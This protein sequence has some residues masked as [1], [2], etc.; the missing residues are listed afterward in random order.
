M[1]RYLLVNSN[2]A[3]DSFSQL[4]ASNWPD[5]I[6]LVASTSYGIAAC[7]RAKLP[8]TT[9]DR[10]S[11]RSEII[12]LGWHNYA[13]LTLFCEHWDSAAQDCTPC[14]KDRS[15]KPFRFGYFDLK[16]LIDSISTKLLMLKN[17]IHYASGQ[18]IF[19][20]PELGHKIISGDFL[21]PDSNVNMFAVLLETFFNDKAKLSPL[22]N[23]STEAPS[24]LSSWRALAR[25]KLRALR[26]VVRAS[27]AFRKNRTYGKYLCF[28]FGHDISYIVPHLLNQQLQLIY[29]PTTSTS[30]NPDII[31]EC[32][33]LWQM[34]LTSEEFKE[35]FSHDEISYFSLVKDSLEKYANSVLPRAIA[36]HDHL[37]KILPKLDI[38]FSLT[39]TV[40]LGLVNRCRMLAAQK[41]G[42]PL[43]TY[44]EGAGY[45]SIVSPIYDFTE[46]V[47]GDAMLCY[48]AGNVEYYKDSGASTKP[49]IP[50]GSAHQDAIRI[51]LRP[52]PPPDQ[53]R[54]VMYAGTVADDNIMHCP[55]NGLV[56]T[57]YHSSQ[58]SI[59]QLLASMPASTKVIA[60]P[61]P[62]DA[63][64]PA[65]LQSAEFRR[66]HLETRRFEKAM[67]GVDL[68]IL[69]FPSTVLLSCI[70]TTAYVFVLAEEGVTGFTPKQKERLEK[71]AYLFENLESLASAVR[72]I[73]VS[74][75]QFPL[76]LD[77]SY[78]MAYSLYMP[79]GKSAERAAK[80]L[81]EF[82]KGRKL[83][84]IHA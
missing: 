62:H 72:N 10:Y 48:G 57:L 25:E 26:G 14:L 27:Q 52:M 30:A 46:V 65:V 11:T 3:L 54:T 69:D 32:H 60:K 53:I 20:L 33:F 16:I 35:F 34:L 51:C 77:D 59:F 67:H 56:S 44:Q 19:Y 28:N 83:Q 36:E 2:Q 7:I 49:L 31:K 75:A 61:N 43:I 78:L 24:I 18:E 76:R 55:N 12:N 6:I 82:S 64:T 45:G 81:S 42:A 40:N 66:I 74:T 29:P 9:L 38:K 8:Y 70:A 23:P 50:V 4:F 39:G 71:R 15:I 1:P 80:V 79:D 68:F 58:A 73:A 21:R 5:D 63:F 47:D 17:F 37:C 22:P 13:S 41:N 84:P